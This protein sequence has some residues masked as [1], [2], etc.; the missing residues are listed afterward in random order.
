[1]MSNRGTLTCGDPRHLIPWV[2]RSG[3]RI[4]FEHALMA[5]WFLLSEGGE[6]LLKICSSTATPTGAASALL[7]VSELAHGPSRALSSAFVARSF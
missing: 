2:A 1:M 4:A 7:I 6:N 5:Q 3:A